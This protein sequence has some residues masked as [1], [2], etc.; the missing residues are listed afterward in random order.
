M[1]RSDGVQRQLPSLSMTHAMATITRLRQLK[2]RIV[3]GG[4]SSAPVTLLRSCLAAT[5]RGYLV[6]IIHYPT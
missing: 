6:F 5:C 2:R 4:E 1:V 3:I